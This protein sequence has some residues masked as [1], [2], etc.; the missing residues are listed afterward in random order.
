MLLS[1]ILTITCVIAAIAVYYVTVGAN[2]DYS[3]HRADLGWWLIFLGIDQALAFPIIAL[4]WSKWYDTH[5]VVWL[6]SYII[7][8]VFVCLWIFV[9][10]CR[11]P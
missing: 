3:T 9:S 2:R 4:W 7:A 5:T 8:C 1:I 6:T 11:K 10:I